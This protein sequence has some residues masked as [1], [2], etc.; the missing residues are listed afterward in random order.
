MGD[1]N[2]RLV[3]NRTQLNA[4]TQDLLLDI[5]ALERMLEE[6]LDSA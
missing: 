4:F 1:L 6:E 2:V 3:S 5:Q